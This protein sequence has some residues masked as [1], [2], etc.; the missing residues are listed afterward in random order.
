MG[1]HR[2]PG[3]MA[4]STL[5]TWTTTTGEEF[6]VLAY[7]QTHMYVVTASAQPDGASL[8]DQSAVNTQVEKYGDWLGTLAQEPDFVQGIIT[9]ETAPDSGPLMRSTIE[10]GRSDRAHPLA[11][12]IM[13]AILDQYPQGSQGVEV[14]VSATFRAPPVELG[15]DGKP[16]PK[17]ERPDEAEQVGKLIAIRAPHLFADLPE[18]GAGDVRLLAADDLIERIRVAYNPADRKAYS[19]A[20]AAGKPRPV[21]LWSNAGPSGSQ[22]HWSWYQHGGGAS[23]TWEFTGF[24]SSVVRADGLLPLLETGADSST[25]ISIIYQPIDPGKGGR[26]V[27]NNYNAA[28][29]RLRDARKPTAKQYE[30]KRNAHKARTSTAR[31]HALI[32][33]AILVTKT[34]TDETSLPAVRTAVNRLGPNARLNLRPCDGMQAVAFAQGLGP[35]GLVTDRHL[36]LPR[37]LMNGA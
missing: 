37:A 12:R 20:R 14:T 25:R 5:S 24:T 13:G 23:V 35:L 21:T 30:D 15:L 32:D 2:L 1:S 27:E 6:A 31:G 26:I 33:F 19:D 9:I 10:A 8:L 34:V 18:C 29:G 3:A 11:K 36:L 28:D 7:P 22:E 4:S 17:S 16:I